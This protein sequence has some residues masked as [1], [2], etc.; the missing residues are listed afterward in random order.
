MEMIQAVVAQKTSA[1]FSSF[2]MAPNSAGE[3]VSGSRRLALPTAV[4][5]I[6]FTALAEGVSKSAGELRVT[7]KSFGKNENIN[8]DVTGP[9]EVLKNLMVQFWALDAEGNDLGIVFQSADHWR[10]EKAKASLQTSERPATAMLP[11]GRTRIHP[12]CHSSESWNL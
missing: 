9:E 7:L 2:A 5:S 4:E 1:N 8:F 6:E 12:Q 10:G 3:T 11:M